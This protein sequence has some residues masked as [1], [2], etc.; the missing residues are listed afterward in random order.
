MLWFISSSSFYKIALSMT[1]LFIKF[2]SI[3]NSK[4]SLLNSTQLLITWW[5]FFRSVH[6]FAGIYERCGKAD[7]D[8]NF[9]QFQD[10]QCCILVISRELVFIWLHVSL[11]ACLIDCLP[12]WLTLPRWLSGIT[13]VLFDKHVQAKGTGPFLAPLYVVLGTHC[14]HT[15]CI[16][17]TLFYVHTTYYT[18]HT[19]RSLRCF[20]Y[21]LHTHHTHLCTLF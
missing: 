6:H 5:S 1:S 8:A 19:S 2:K 21:T 12:Y 16:L 13:S 3:N 11:T 17:F 15:T 10:C 18:L 14:L 4:W 7:K 20:T 9:V